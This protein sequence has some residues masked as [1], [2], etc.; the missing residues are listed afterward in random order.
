MRTPLPFVLETIHW[1]VDK[2]NGDNSN[3]GQT[4]EEPVKDIQEILD[5]AQ[6]YYNYGGFPSGITVQN[7]RCMYPNPTGTGTPFIFNW[8]VP[9]DGYL[10]LWWQFDVGFGF[11]MDSFPGPKVKLAL[12]SGYQTVWLYDG[13]LKLSDSRYIPLYGIQVTV[14]TGSSYW[15]SS[16]YSDISAAPVNPLSEIY[17][18]KRHVIHVNG[19]WFEENIQIRGN[20]AFEG[21]GT[22]FGIPFL[23]S[24]VGLQHS[25]STIV[26]D[27]PCRLPPI[28]V[29]SGSILMDGFNSGTLWGTGGS[30]FLSA[31]I[32]EGDTTIAV[33]SLKSIGISIQAGNPLMFGDSLDFPELSTVNWS[34]TPKASGS[35]LLE[36]T[37]DHLKLSG[38][39]AYN[40]FP[41]SGN[42]SY[43]MLLGLVEFKIEY[44][45]ISLVDGGSNSQINFT[46]PLSAHVVNQLNSAGSPDYIIPLEKIFLTNP[47]E[48][49]WPENTPVCYFSPPSI[50]FGFGVQSEFRKSSL[51]S[52]QAGIIIQPTISLY[53]ALKLI[54]GLW[55]IKF[56]DRS[57]IITTGDGSCA[58]AK[59]PLVHQRILFDEAYIL[60]LGKGHLYGTFPWSQEYPIGSGTYLEMDYP[61]LT[62][63]DLFTR[64]T[65]VYL[66]DGEISD[67]IRKESGTPD[68]RTQFKRCMFA[69]TTIEITEV[70]KKILL[71]ELSEDTLDFNLFID[72]NTY[73]EGTSNKDPAPMSNPDE[74]LAGGA[75]VPSEVAGGNAFEILVEE[76][77]HTPIIGAVG[78]IWNSSLTVRVEAAESDADGKLYFTADDGT[79][80]LMVHKRSDYSFPNP[81]ELVVS[82]NHPSPTSVVGTPIPPTSEII[83]TP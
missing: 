57:S 53:F 64:S 32:S 72:P 35:S 27:L 63:L 74:Y 1:H 78:T 70:I 9:G 82:N 62:R 22:S 47:I 38:T 37:Q 65:F 7:S 49:D 75:L 4:S 48:N 14:N 36:L 61:P 77:D 25:E 55:D 80:K 26:G 60:M 44:D 10:Y 18:Y 16:G 11:A 69:E 59:W 13:I 68:L 54:T 43:L 30:T 29:I 51:C 40:N 71:G 66:N 19:A 21:Q 28:C 3:S 34:T 39:N 76:S 67:L 45:S 56:N 81:I 52:S 2:A 5:R 24:I 79:Y 15:P 83:E 12:D 33:D 46:T 31:G 73:P 23:F 6:G 58:I 17:K 42:I 50:N 20:F 41:S 8:D